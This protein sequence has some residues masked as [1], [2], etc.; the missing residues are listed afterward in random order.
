MASSCYPSYILMSSMDD[1]I[2]CHCCTIT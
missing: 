2:R 1:A